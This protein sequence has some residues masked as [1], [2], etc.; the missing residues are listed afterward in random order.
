[1][2]K[3]QE[4]NGAHA[5]LILFGKKRSCERTNGT[6]FYLHM[7]RALLLV[8]VLQIVNPGCY[9]EKQSGVISSGI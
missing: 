8:A 6:V 5:C 4:S 3:L 9:S 1:L 2:E 7:S